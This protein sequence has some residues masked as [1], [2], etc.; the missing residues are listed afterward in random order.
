M[1]QPL[2]LQLRKGTTVILIIISE[3]KSEME[4]IRTAPP[5]WQQIMTMITGTLDQLSMKNSDPNLNSSIITIKSDM[6]IFRLLKTEKELELS[7]SKMS[8]AGSATPANM[9]L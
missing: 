8:R 3:C 5:P 6:A 4:T 1:D 7:Q 9:Q 2:V